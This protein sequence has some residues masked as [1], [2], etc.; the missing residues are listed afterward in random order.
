MLS[1]VIVN[2]NAGTLLSDTVRFLTL[3]KTRQTLEIIVVDNCSEDSSIDLLQSSQSDT[4][5]LSIIR[6]DKNLGFATACNIGVKN[7]SGQW[8]LFLN[9]DCEIAQNA[10]QVMLDALESTPGIGM[11]GGLLL[12]SDGTEQVGGRRTV[13]TPWRSLVRVLR[14]SGFLS[15]RYPKLFPD[16]QLHKEA[17]P[18][19]PIEVEAIS[20]ACMLVKLETLQRIGLLDEGYFM[21]CEDLDL[22]MRIRASGL[23]ILFVPGAKILH[24]KGTCSKSRPVFVEW[25]KHKGMMR[26]YKKFFYRQYPGVLM[27]LVAIGIWLRFFA[28]A[29]FLSFNLYLKRAFKS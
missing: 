2:Y 17:L 27:I 29:V 21:H 18:N 19:A 3:A 8:I 14:L 7:A 15:K 28:K 22:C 23:K 1:V 6:N 20:G 12:N 24:H 13:P 26:F 10:I 4:K 11:V 25:H 9:P 16:F 5:S